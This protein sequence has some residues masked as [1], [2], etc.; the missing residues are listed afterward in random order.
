LPEYTF[1]VFTSQNGVDAFFTELHALGKDSRAL[2]ALRVAAIGPG[3]AEALAPYG[4]VPDVVPLNFRG[5]ALAE[6]IMQAAGSLQGVKVLLARAAVAR[7]VL[8]ETLRAAGAEVDVV[9]AYET[10]GASPEARETLR[11]LIERRGIDVI[12]FT[13]SSTVQHTLNALGSDGPKLLEGLILASIGP[14]TTQTARDHGLDVQI[15]ADEY[16]I[17]GLVSAIH[18]YFAQAQTP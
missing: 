11:G 8:P 2:G 18:S 15:T 17:E 5:E 13:A 4:I 12:T 14:I 16:T 9:T 7:D 1:V 3:T 6:A 10:H